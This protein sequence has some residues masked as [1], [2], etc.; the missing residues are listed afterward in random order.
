M[1]NKKNLI[2][3]EFIG[4]NVEVVES[5][6]KYLVGLKGKVIDE[7]KKTI[8][9]E[10]RDKREKIIPKMGNVLEFTLSGNKKVT[11]CGEEIMTRPE[12]RIKKKFKRWKY[13]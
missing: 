13:L 10:K 12:D 11:I 5:K 3:H 7:T 8:K 6:N 4:L 9:I 2:R 1:R